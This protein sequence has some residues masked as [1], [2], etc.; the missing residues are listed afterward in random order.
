MTAWIFC[1]TLMGFK[2]CAIATEC[3]KRVRL[4]LW[5]KSYRQAYLL[6]VYWVKIMNKSAHNDLVRIDRQVGI[7]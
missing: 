1:E 3:K 6:N 4:G 2:F 5:V 7:V